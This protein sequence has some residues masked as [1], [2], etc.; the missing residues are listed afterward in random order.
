VGG[1]D[2]AFPRTGRN[3]DQFKSRGAQA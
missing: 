1:G 2:N 3:R